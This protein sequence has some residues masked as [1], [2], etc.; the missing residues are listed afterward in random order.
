MGKFRSGLKVA[1][2]VVQLVQAHD[3]GLVELEE[4]AMSYL[5]QH[6]LAFKVSNLC[7]MFACVHVLCWAAA[8]NVYRCAHVCFAPKQEC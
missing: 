2:V 5:V 1:N 7:V 6:A 8:S 3:S 4:V